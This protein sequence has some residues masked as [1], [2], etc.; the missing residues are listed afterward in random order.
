MYDS[1]FQ[2]I[3]IENQLEDGKMFLQKKPL[4]HK[5][6]FDKMPSNWPLLTVGWSLSVQVFRK[7]Q[8]NSKLYVEETRKEIST[9][10]PLIQLHFQKFAL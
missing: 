9:L 3:T 7:I 10:S 2:S 4:E 1:S 5:V 6:K 8:I